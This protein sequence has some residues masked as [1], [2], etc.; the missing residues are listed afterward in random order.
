MKQDRYKH[1]MLHEELL[2]IRDFGPEVATL[3]EQLYFLHYST[4]TNSHTYTTETYDAVIKFKNYMKKLDTDLYDVLEIY[5]P[6]GDSS[7]DSR[8]NSN[9]SSPC[10]CWTYSCYL[11]KEITFLDDPQKAQVKWSDN[12]D[13]YSPFQKITPSGGAVV[14]NNSSSVMVDNVNGNGGQKI[15]AQVNEGYELKIRITAYGQSPISGNQPIQKL[16]QNLIYQQGNSLATPFASPFGDC[17]TLDMTLRGNDTIAVEGVSNPNEPFLIDVKRFTQNGKMKS[18]NVGNVQLFTSNEFNIKKLNIEIL[19][20]R[21]PWSDWKLHGHG[22]PPGWNRVNGVSGLTLVAQD[23]TDAISENASG[24]NIFFQVDVFIGVEL[25]YVVSVEIGG[26]IGLKFDLQGNH[27]F[28]SGSYLQ[29][30]VDIGVAKASGRIEGTK[31]WGW[32]NSKEL[33]YAMRD[34]MNQFIPA[35]YEMPL[36]KGFKD[37]VTKTYRKSHLDLGGKLSTEQELSEN[38]FKY[39]FETDHPILNFASLSS[40]QSKNETTIAFGKKWSKSE[41]SEPSPS[42]PSSTS[43]SLSHGN[44]WTANI[45]NMLSE[46]ILAKV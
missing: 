38:A 9:S 31:E 41:E 45:L 28:K 36:P 46:Y 7:I 4:S 18:I 33:T 25:F 23:F 16:D 37:P 27:I 11:F 29:A 14:N 17:Y 40:N 20:V 15:L 43:S 42:I 24:A 5:K 44:M 13:L 26:F 10:G 3:N 35:S 30:Q 32:T 2:T 8:C 6:C 21:A 1:L 12:S 39:E 19:D 34:W 22:S